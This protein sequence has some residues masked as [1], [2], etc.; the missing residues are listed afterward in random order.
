[1][2][3]EGRG[4]AVDPSPPPPAPTRQTGARRKGPNREGR[5]RTEAP[6]GGAS[7]PRGRPPGRFGPQ[8]TGPQARR[9]EPAALAIAID[10]EP[11]DRGV[12]SRAARASKARAGA[13]SG[14]GGERSSVRQ[15]LLQ[16]VAEVDSTQRVHA[17]LRDQR[18][19][20][21]PYPHAC[22]THK[23]ILHTHAYL[24]RSIRTTCPRFRMSEPTMCGVGRLLASVLV[25]PRR[26]RRAGHGELGKQWPR[27][28]YRVHLREPA[29]VHARMDV[30]GRGYGGDGA[31]DTPHAVVAAK[32]PPVD[33]R[34]GAPAFEAAARGGVQEGVRAGVV[35]GAGLAQ[36]GGDG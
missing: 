8:P 3:F 9:T 24:R 5:R 35:A 6:R 7:A 30:E 18:G 19:T 4:A 16:R 2:P 23:R 28:L 20:G 12:S 34:G 1:M 21:A 32:G 13:A 31:R 15:S 14:A 17:R 11:D 36:H 27:P 25:R 22:H 26:R 10:K 29:P 33:A